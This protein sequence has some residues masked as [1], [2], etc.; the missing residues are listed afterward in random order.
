MPEEEGKVLSGNEV[1]KYVKIHYLDKIKLVG[2]TSNLLNVLIA[3]NR[4]FSNFLCKL[5][6]FGYFILSILQNIVILKF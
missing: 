1:S 2:L 3:L 6:N 5:V 4:K